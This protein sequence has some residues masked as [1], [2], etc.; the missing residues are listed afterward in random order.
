VRSRRD[1]REEFDVDEQEF[2]ASVA[3]RTGLGREEAADLTRAALQAIAQRLSEGTVRDLVTG[4]PDG[5]DGEV[6]AVKG[7]PSRQVGLE[8][9]EEKVSERTGLRR[10]EVH[11]GFRAV[12]ATL[13][14]A[15]PEDTYE[16]VVG[17]LPGQ[18]RDLVAEEPR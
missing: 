3:A 10:D 17:Q 5:L 12:L 7:R 14:E 18:F 8:E 2:F 16:K 15:V 9:I 4:L 11:S 6:R 1:H 13:R